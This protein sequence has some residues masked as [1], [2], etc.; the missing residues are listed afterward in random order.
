M[1]LRRAIFGNPLKTSNLEGQSLSKTKALAIFSSDLLSTIAYA[2]EEILIVLGVMSA[3]RFTVPLAILI[4]ILVL[5]LAFSYLNT[6]KEYPTGGGAFSVAYKNLGENFGILAAA[7]LLLG[8]T[9]TVAV[10]LSASVEAITSAFPSLS[11]HSIGICLFILTSLTLTNLRGTQ[12]SA[13]LLAFPTYCFIGTILL[14]VI[15]GLFKNTPVEV[16][17][18]QYVSSDLSF[19]TIL[20]LLQAFASGC[21]VTS[22]IESIAGGVPS[23][24]RPK[25]KNSQV[26]LCCVICVLL[27]MFLGVT[28][29]TH[30]FNIVH[31]NT[32]TVLSQISKIV[33]GGTGV[34]YYL[35]QVMTTVILIMAANTSFSGFP[36][37]ASV[38]ANEKYIPTSFAN[39]GDRLAFSNGIILLAFVSA[40]LLIIFKG[41]THSLI[42]LYSVGIF[43]SFTLSQ[44]GLII[45]LVREKNKNWYIKTFFCSIGALTTFCI[46]L[47]TICGKFFDGAWIVMIIIPLIML[48]F[49]KIKISYNKNHKSLDPK[50]GGLGQIVRFKN[51]MTNATVVVPVTKIHKGTLAALKFAQNI[52]DDVSAVIVNINQRE[53]NKLKLAWKAMDFNIPLVILDSPYRSV[54]S[55]FL[56]YLDE[57]DKRTKNKE[58]TIV[59]LP[60][61]IPE[62]L[63]QN[64]L[65]NQTA[66]ILKTALLYKK[67]LTDKPRI[68][69]DVPYQL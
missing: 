51:N 23:F 4:T 66:T 61:F 43:I 65:H 1:N 22:G 14:L 44:A 7:S 63:W 24:R 42:A 36:R 58:P 12:E 29:L 11:Q 45:H 38:L 3:A 15:C 2:T 10:S 5:I 34:F 67:K 20:M 48:I 41:N 47:I 40:V 39:L 53:T 33:G 13:S 6:I 35:V 28:Y 37:L 62:K 49:K 31:S 30:K 59:V 19:A 57:L 26:T 16:S 27:V 8:Y 46:L 60:S 17:G 52:S 56:E 21:T 50:S 64:I 68:I 54:I 32:E 9:L 18:H 25:I 55:P 69:V